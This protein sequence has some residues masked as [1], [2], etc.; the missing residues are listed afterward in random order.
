MEKTLSREVSETNVHL[1]YETTVFTCCKL[2][3]GAFS[4]TYFFLDAV[5]QVVVIFSVAHNEHETF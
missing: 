1:I 5:Y 4:E 2:F 3:L